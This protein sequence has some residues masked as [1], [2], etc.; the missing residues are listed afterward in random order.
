MMERKKKLYK[1][2]NVWG[3]FRRKKRNERK[4]TKID[5]KESS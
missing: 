3:K 2:D 1:D 4:T 5:D